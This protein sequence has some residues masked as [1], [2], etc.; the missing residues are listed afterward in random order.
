MGFIGGLLTHTFGISKLLVVALNT[1]CLFA[2]VTESDE[3]I[4][5]VALHL[6]LMSIACLQSIASAIH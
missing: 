5:L 1:A 2:V 4:S 6:A 3:K